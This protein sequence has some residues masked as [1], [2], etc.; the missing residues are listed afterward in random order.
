MA[1][2]S[3]KNRLLFVKDA[4]AARHVRATRTSLEI[5]ETFECSAR[6]GVR[7]P[8]LLQPHDGLECS[9]SRPR[10]S[11]S[12]C[13]PPAL[14]RCDLPLRVREKCRDV[15]A[16]A[17][18]FQIAWSLPRP[19]AAKGTRP[20]V[21]PLER[22]DAF[23]GGEALADMISKAD[24]LP[25][26]LERRTLRRA[27][28]KRRTR[29][30][31]G[32]GPRS[33]RGTGALT[34]SAIF[35]VQPPLAVKAYERSAFERWLPDRSRARVFLAR[36]R[37]SISRRPALAREPRRSSSLERLNADD[38]RSRA[39]R[40][41]RREASRRARRKPR[42]AQASA[43]SV[44]RVAEQRAAPGRSSRH[45]RASRSRSFISAP[46]IAGSVGGA[47]RRRQ[48]FEGLPSRPAAC[49][50]PASPDE[51]SHVPSRGDVPSAP[52]AVAE[53]T[54]LRR[55]PFLL[56][57]P[58]TITRRDPKGR[59]RFQR[60]CYLFSRRRRCRRRWPLD[61]ERMIAM[62]VTEACEQPR[63]RS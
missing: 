26:V 39:D 5:E 56:R 3:P 4:Q 43:R 17:V 36:S 59:R 28:G 57:A 53:A 18:G 54:L 8:C 61:I 16:G 40:S 46:R 22:I 63:L 9:P 52:A 45:A 41:S 31:R 2:S 19:V 27:R 14:P 47:R 51:R 35:A 15:G 55:T 60:R 34:M 24:G 10:S 30:H 42:Q 37:R 21:V 13:K 23:V 6:R 25:G 62:H 1:R 58:A 44:T 29:T 32:S 38:M 50:T 33:R 20:G 11:G 7:A 49:K 12:D 48:L